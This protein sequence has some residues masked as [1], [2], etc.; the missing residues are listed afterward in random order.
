MRRTKGEGP[1]LAGDSPSGIN[2]LPGRLER[3][4]K[5]KSQALQIASYF[6][7]VKDG[8]LEHGVYRRLQ[9]CA[10]YLLF[11]NYP[12]QNTVRLKA[13][14]FCKAHLLCPFCAI[15]RGAKALQAYSKRYEVI[16]SDIGSEGRLTPFMVTLTVKD[17][18]D[19]LERFSK[20]HQSF[21]AL[22]KKRHGK[23]SGHSTW[24]NAKGGVA[25]YEVKRGVGSGLWH[26]HLH[27]IVLC[28]PGRPVDAHLLSAEWLK[29][30]GDSFIV[31]IRPIKEK[32][33]E[34]VIGGFMEVFKYAVKFSSMENIDVI[35]CWRLLQGKNL[36]TSFGLFRGVEVPE[37]LSDEQLSDDERYMDMLYRYHFSDANY[38]PCP[39]R[40]ET[41]DDLKLSRKV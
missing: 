40:N 9:G 7:K 3:Y 24:A 34:G 32:E 19:L 10:N 29:I 31:D 23:G 8:N 17:G 2:E 6:E 27:A 12:D 18:P 22:N 28:H 13:A 33:G 5:A 26:P 30:T 11:R 14:R 35:E 39:S 15:R 25:S 4:S 20:L 1:S 16:Q 36:L 41:L 21:Q 37:D 38:Q